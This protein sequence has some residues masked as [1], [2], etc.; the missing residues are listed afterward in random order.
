MHHL[1]ARPRTPPFPASLCSPLP[2]C[3]HQ[4]HTQGLLR[5]SATRRAVTGVPHLRAIQPNSQPSI[6]NKCLFLKEAFSDF[7][8]TLCP[9]RFFYFLTVIVLCKYVSL[10]VSLCFMSVSHFKLQAPQGGQF[11]LFIYSA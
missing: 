2:S 4:H 3:C 6:R 11:D 7:H 9:F 10:Y 1:A 5:F 8:W